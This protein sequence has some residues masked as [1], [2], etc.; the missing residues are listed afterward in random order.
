M[1]AHAFGQ[2]VSVRKVAQKC[3]RCSERGAK[4][5]RSNKE[6]PHGQTEFIRG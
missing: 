4:A 3:T 6:H 5:E 1:D 2:N